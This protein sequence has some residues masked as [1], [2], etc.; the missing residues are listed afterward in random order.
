MN[1]FE[2]AC[3]PES[4]LLLARLRSAVGKGGGVR[5]FPDSSA[6]LLPIFQGEI[7]ATVVAVDG[8]NADSA[9]R[10]IRQLRAAVPTHAIIAWC[11]LRTS[12]SRLLL[13]T[14][15]RRCSVIRRSSG[16]RCTGVEASIGQ[17]FSCARTPA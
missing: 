11:E 13:C 14:H 6:A 10:T 12:P 17:P 15:G 16:R 1:C 9:L 5:H 2:V 3:I 7:D 8:A 4:P